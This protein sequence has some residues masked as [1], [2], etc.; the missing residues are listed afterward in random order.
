MPRYYPSRIDWWIYASI[1]LAIVA[2]IGSGVT[3]W[4]VEPNAASTALP[5]IVTAAIAAIAVPL[6]LL[7]GT[8]YTLEP[9]RLLIQ[10]GPLKWVVPLA[11][12]HSIAPTRNPLSS[13]ALSLDRLLI[14]YGPDRK[15][16]MISPEDKAGFLRELEAL[17][18]TL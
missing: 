3:V 4:I 6:M 7:R 5:I 12:I 11:E 18:G 2:I 8:G 17:R 15:Q 13:P 16:I 9:T 10:S 1:G 14:T